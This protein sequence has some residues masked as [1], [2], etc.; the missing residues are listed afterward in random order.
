MDD[1][2]SVDMDEA[3][4]HF[5][6]VSECEGDGLALLVSCYANSIFRWLNEHTIAGRPSHAT[7]H[8]RVE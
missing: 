4:R 3:R 1:E 7:F 8:P 6:A 5:I 2:R